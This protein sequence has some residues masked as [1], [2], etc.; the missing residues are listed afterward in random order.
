MCE[1][2]FKNHLLRSHKGLKLKLYRNAY[3][4]SFYKNGVFI[5]VACVLS[6]LRQLK[7]STEITM[8]I[9]EFG[10][11]CYLTAD[12]F[13]RVLQ[14]CSLSSPLSNVLYY[15]CPNFWI[16]LVAMANKML[17]LRQQ[18]SKIIS[19]ETIRGIKLKFWGNADKPLTTGF[20]CRCWST[21]VAIGT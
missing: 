12:I 15:I 8:G 16:V 6:L 5:P 20:D 2:I 7:V 9:V 13:T 11:Y 1:N 14:A 3:N 17:N 19:L 21:V 18:Y 4:I 10:F